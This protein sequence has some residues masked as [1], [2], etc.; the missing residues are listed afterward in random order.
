MWYRKY[1]NPLGDF[2]VTQQ[3]SNLPT[4]TSLPPIMLPGQPSMSP[5]SYLTQ[6]A[7]T[8]LQPINNLPVVNPQPVDLPPLPY[9]PPQ[10]LPGPV[11]GPIQPIFVR[12]P[13]QPVGLVAPSPTPVS[14]IDTVVNA[15][16]DALPAH[17]F[18]VT[19]PESAKSNTGTYILIS[20]A[21]IGLIGGIYYYRKK[22]K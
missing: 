5:E 20:L 14:K 10:G 15:M 12:G 9:S 19:P 3:G 11:P 7:A 13:E 17:T 1:K 8:S 21:S 6:K 4:F 22:H 18:T 16:V 2:S